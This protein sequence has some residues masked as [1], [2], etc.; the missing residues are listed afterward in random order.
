M[1]ARRVSLAALKG[2]HPHRTYGLNWLK[3]TRWTRGQLEIQALFVPDGSDR[4]EDYLTCWIRASDFPFLILGSRWYRSVM[5]GKPL[6]LRRLK[7]PNA[8][9]FRV[10]GVDPTGEGDKL[11]LRPAYMLAEGKG[12]NPVLEFE[13]FDA[14]DE[15][16]SPYRIY[17]PLT[18]AYRSHYFDINVALPSIFGGLVSGAMKNPG[19][20][21]W[22]PAGTEWIDRN[23]REA[24]IT[25]AKAL[26]QAVVKRLARSLFSEQGKAAFIAIHRWIQSSFVAPAEPTKPGS[27]A[28]L[29]LV[30]LPYHCAVWDASVI[31]LANDSEG[32]P[33]LLV[34]HI[35]SF[36]APEP[37]NELEIVAQP[38]TQCGGDK[39]DDGGGRGGKLLD[40]DPD[41]LVDDVEDGWDSRLEPISIEDVVA[42]DEQIRRRVP[43]V[44]RPEPIE[45]DRGGRGG[46]EKVP[47]D[48][49]STQASGPTGRGVA[50]LVFSDDDAA[51][52]PNQAVLESV[53]AI[54]RAMGNFVSGH[55]RHGIKA[56]ARF[57]PDDSKVFEFRVPASESERAKS[58]AVPRQF[59]VAEVTVGGRHAYVIEPERRS[60]HQPLP[61]GLIWL[62]GVDGKRHGALSTDEIHRIVQHLETAAR[63]GHSWPR[64][65]AKTKRLGASAVIHAAGSPPTAEGLMRFSDRIANGLLQI[66]GDAVVIAGR[67]ART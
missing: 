40:P 35:E 7:I 16:E 19:F 61:L 54:R 20:E 23:S 15:D 28:W 64:A 42:R 6:G 58:L 49:G 5:V 51:A 33:Q 3:A 32:R 41:E 55:A 36:D 18:E 47:V 4:S 60:E 65:V 53:E 39:G 2:A 52:E 22:D 43:R 31:E 24:R 27:H 34:L 13:G 9:S 11:G 44:V 37:F 12:N 50:P 29:P 66:I 45:G 62:S 38:S 10:R 14:E 25:P 1:K 67:A 63:A 57:L 48:E 17:L 8:Q 21:A 46:R 56:R 59:V 30:R 26:P